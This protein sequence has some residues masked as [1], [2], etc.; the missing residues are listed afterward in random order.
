MSVHLTK[1]L[2]TLRL[3][4]F[5]LTRCL[6]TLRARLQSS[7]P[8]TSGGR[9]RRARRALVRATLSHVET[10]IYSIFGAPLGRQRGSSSP[11]EHPSGAFCL[12]QNA[13][14]AALRAAGQATSGKSNLWW[15]RARRAL[16]CGWLA[17]H[18]FPR[19]RAFTCFAP[20]I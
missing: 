9:A 2:R 18:L 20:T 11:L 15:L 7:F 19:A 4:W 10:K 13:Q 6:R 14:R 3:L 17:T 5:H 8:G 12:R 1:C 16:V